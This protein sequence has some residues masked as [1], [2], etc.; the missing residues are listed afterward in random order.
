MASLAPADSPEPGTRVASAAP[1]AQNTQS[2]NSQ[3]EGFFS[4]LARKVG[5]GGTADTTATAS[6]PATAKPKVAEARPQRPE[7][8]TPKTSAPKAD[9]R[10]AAAHP[11]LKPTVADTATA[12]P[13]PAQAAAPAAPSLVAG[14][15]PIV[16]ANSFESRFSAV[17]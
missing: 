13:D 4:S 7:A 14:A 12:A 6:Q 1:G 16:S 2:Q 15:Q 11:P 5:L 17:K 9:T 3:S 10:Q 8:S